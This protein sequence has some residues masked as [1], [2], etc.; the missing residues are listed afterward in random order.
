MNSVAMSYTESAG[1]VR[2]ERVPAA[3]EC[4]S[5]TEEPTF[6]D[7]LRRGD[8]A[9]FDALVNRHHSALIRMAMGYVSTREVAE[10]VV[11]DTWMAVVESLNRFEGRSS[12]KTW[13]FGILIHKAKD[14]GVRDKRHTTFS[15]FETLDDENDAA[16]DPSRFYQSGEWAGH[17]AVPPQSW[18]D[19]T[20]EKLLASRQTVAAMSKAIDEL[21]VGLK[22]VLVLRDVEGVDSKEV[23]ELLKIT[24]TNLYVRLHRARERVRR[25]VEQYLEG[26]CKKHQRGETQR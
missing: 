21:P 8:E 11:Q 7:R 9:A 26:R 17:W 19:Q 12:L 3:T 16:V 10:E 22:T 24:E 13:I 1:Y 25:T 6:L 23:C 14:R 4:L 15:E 5:T 18:D 2:V 20:P